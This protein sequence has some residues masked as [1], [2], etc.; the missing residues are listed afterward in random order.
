MNLLISRILEEVNV[1][2]TCVVL[3]YRKSVMWVESSVGV[4]NSSSHALSAALWYISRRYITI[5]TYW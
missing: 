2:E 5:L 3:L 1:D 4:D